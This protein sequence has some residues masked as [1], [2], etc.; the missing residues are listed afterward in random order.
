MLKVL[1][2]PEQRCYIQAA[3]SAAAPT[4]LYKSLLACVGVEVLM[5]VAALSDLLTNNVDD[6]VDSVDII[7]DIQ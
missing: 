7:K 6:F 2:L 4:V 3:L 5:A 1:L